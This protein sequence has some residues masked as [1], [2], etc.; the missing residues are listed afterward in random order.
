MQEVQ[1]LTLL[2]NAGRRLSVGVSCRE[3]RVGDVE[4]A[5]ECLEHYAIFI[6]DP[7]HN[8]DLMKNPLI[9]GVIAMA[10]SSG[11]LTINGYIHIR[12][13]WQYYVEQIEVQQ[14][15]IRKKAPAH[16]VGMRA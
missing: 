11:N 15:A 13:A 2:R 12:E 9:L 5:K 8:G 4:I 10:D 16:P 7:S 1:F 3:I 14:E 6:E